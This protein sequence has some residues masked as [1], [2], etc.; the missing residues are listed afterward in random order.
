MIS[1]KPYLIPIF[2]PTTMMIVIRL[3]F[4]LITERAVLGKC[5]SVELLRSFSAGHVASARLNISGLRNRVD[6]Q[7]RRHSSAETC[8]SDTRHSTVMYI[9]CA[10]SWF[11]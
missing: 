6:L 7:A 3:F 2:S 10:F 4:L 1:D 11:Y 9:A 8:R 5:V